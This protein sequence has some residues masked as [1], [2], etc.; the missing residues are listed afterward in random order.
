[1][2]RLRREHHDDDGELHAVTDAARPGEWCWATQA[3]E[4][5]TTMQALV[6]EAITQA[7][8]PSIRMRWPPASVITAPPR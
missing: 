4:A 3:A 1:M 8:A 5:F 6:S 7:G 2:C